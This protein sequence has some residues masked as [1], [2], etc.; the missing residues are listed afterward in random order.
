MA[1]ELNPEAVACA[2]MVMIRASAFPDLPV[3]NLIRAAI[4]AY[5]AADALPIEEG[6]MV[7][8]IASQALTDEADAFHRGN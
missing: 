3:R 2:D 6:V 4:R 7:A 5:L 1:N 8:Q